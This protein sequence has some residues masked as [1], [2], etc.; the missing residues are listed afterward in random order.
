MAGD[1]RLELPRLMLFIES[2]PFG[3][4]PR[5]PLVP[6]GLIAG[7]CPIG[8]I[9]LAD[10]ALDPNEDVSATTGRHDSRNWRM[11]SAAEGPSNEVNDSV[12]RGFLNREALDHRA[13]GIASATVDRV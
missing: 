7:F 9:D 6:T 4:N 5:V 1:N 2:Q 3:G 13:E 10:L 8:R 12:F 11:L